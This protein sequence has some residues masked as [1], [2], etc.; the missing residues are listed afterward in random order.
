[1]ALS[2]P[3]SRPTL[4]VG[5]GSALYVRPT[6]VFMHKYDLHLIPIGEP[7]TAIPAAFTFIPRV[8]DLLTTTPCCGIRHFEVVRVYAQ[9]PRD[10][11]QQ[12]RIEVLVKDITIPEPFTQ[13]KS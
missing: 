7:D 12:G 13:P 3:L 10:P 4:R 11:D 8:G 1:M 2:V 6:R 5:G 9:E